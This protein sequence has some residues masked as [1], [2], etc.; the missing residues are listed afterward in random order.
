MTW[1]LRRRPM[2][3][4]QSLLSGALMLVVAVLFTVTAAHRAHRSSTTQHTVP[5]V[6]QVVAAAQT[7]HSSRSGGY[8]T[9]EYE[10]LEP[11]GDLVWARAHGRENDALVGQTLRVVVDPQDRTYAELAGAP[12]AGWSGVWLG[13]ISFTLVAVLMLW[14]GLRRLRPAARTWSGR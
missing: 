2:T 3:A 4:R 14:T 11:S 9:S 6:G 12:M 13:G 5:V 1:G 10:V 7:H 8:W